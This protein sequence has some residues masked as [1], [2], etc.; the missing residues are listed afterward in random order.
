[1]ESMAARQLQR[2]MEARNAPEDVAG[3]TEVNEALP[4]FVLPKGTIVPIVIESSVSSD[5]GGQIKMLVP[6]DVLGRNLEHV[7]IPA[8]T[9][10]VSGYGAPSLVGQKRLVIGANRMNLPDGRY[11]EFRNTNSYGPLGQAGTE[12]DLDRHLL[13]RFGAVGALAV[14]STGLNAASGP[15]A[16]FGGRRSFRA[17]AA[18]SGSQQVNQIIAQ[19]LEQQIQRQPTIGLKPGQNGALVLNEDINMK[20]PYYEGRTDQ[21]R[22]AEQ[23]RH[24]YAPGRYESPGFQNGTPP[25]TG[26]GQNRQPPSGLPERM[27][28]TLATERP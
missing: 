17:R 13:A 18:Q 5:L 3:L 25:Q 16:L 11:V 2:N 24:Y 14:V 19:I 27:H 21:M 8:G 6:T 9:E 7:L 26:P 28:R 22:M 23:S 4:R 12:G 10:I 15:A 20:R 1:M